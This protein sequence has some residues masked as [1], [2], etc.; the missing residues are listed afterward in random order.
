[1]IRRKQILCAR[2][3]ANAKVWKHSAESG[4]VLV[5][6]FGLGIFYSSAQQICCRFFLKWCFGCNPRSKIAL[7]K[8]IRKDPRW[9]Q[10]KCHQFLAEKL[11]TWPWSKWI[12]LKHSLPYS[13]F[14]S[15]SFISSSC[16]AGSL[17]SK[18]KKPSLQ[19]LNWFQVKSK[20]GPC[21]SPHWQ[22]GLIDR[23]V[24]FINNRN[25]VDQQ[26]TKVLVWTSP[27]YYTWEDKL[28]VNW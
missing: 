28:G 17:V 25:C 9:N 13:G 12:P 23:M 3:S 27:G 8:V 16:P 6:V 26:G 7:F 15:P 11:T 14:L 1:M 24:G 18:W 19:W 22:S 21:T 2:H 10:I 5:L 4:T 20:F